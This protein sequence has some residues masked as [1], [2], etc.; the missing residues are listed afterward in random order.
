M[1]DS[2]GTI[3]PATT[4]FEDELKEHSCA[5]NG[6]TNIAVGGTTAKQWSGF[7]YME[8]VK[9]QAKDHDFI[10]ITLMGNDA[11]AEMPGCA[12]EGKTAAECGDV[13]MKNVLGYMGKILDGIHEANPN[14]RVVGFGYDTMFGGLG[15]EILA[16]QIFP[17][18]WKNKTVPPIRCFNTE[19]I[20]IQG[21]WETLASTRSYVT[22]INLL[23]T[24][25]VAYGDKSA[26][27]G[28]PDLDKMGPRKYWPDFLQCIHPSTSGG[29]ASG[30]MIIMKEFYK[31]F[32]SKALGC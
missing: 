15:C 7:L 14:A 18:C 2:W 12:S 10:W 11:L 6:F 30:A 26:A 1:G 27:I 22:A 3:S 19:L 8:K 23:G 20:R 5:L 28:K 13:L 16:R 29:D 21:A 25:Q 9:K 31:Q 24:T 32:W 4:H 17:Q